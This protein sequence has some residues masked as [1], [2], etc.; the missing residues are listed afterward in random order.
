MSYLLQS[1]HIEVLNRN[2][3]GYYECDE[4]LKIQPLSFQTNEY[5]Q[6]VAELPK[7]CV[8]GNV[9]FNLHTVIKVKSMKPL[10]HIKFDI[11]FSKEEI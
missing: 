10:E 4:C 5:D 9:G 11:S 2:E 7:P 1:K 6:T 3:R 8:C